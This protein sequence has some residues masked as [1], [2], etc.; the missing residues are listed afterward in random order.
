ML[1]AIVGRKITVVRLKD[2]SAYVGE[3]LSAKSPIFHIQFA[4]GTD[5]R[6]DDELECGVGDGMNYVKITAVVV[7]VGENSAELWVTA[8]SLVPGME[9]APRV[10]APGVI[11]EVTSRDES[12]TVSV[13]DVSESGLLISSHTSFPV[14]SEVD[15]R[16]DFNGASLKLVAKVV[17]SNQAVKTDAC[18]LGLQILDADRLSRA[19][20]NHLVSSLLRR[21]GLSRAA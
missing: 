17:R 18:E 1:S 7:T 10:I 12:A 9:R 13:C 5:L 11:A 14:G 20:W 16:M 21:Y 15:I 3:V 19:R 6:P 4:G 2:K 8:Q